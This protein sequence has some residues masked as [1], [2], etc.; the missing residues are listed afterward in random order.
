[1]RG[2]ADGGRAGGRGCRHAHVPTPVSRSIRGRTAAARLVLSSNDRIIAI[3]GVAGAGQSTMLRP[4]AA[5]LKAEGRTLLGLAFQNKMVSD[6]VDAGL[7]AQTIASFLARHQ[8]LLEPGAPQHER[9]VPISRRRSSSSTRVS[10]NAN[11]AQLKLNRLANLLAV[12]RMV[13]M[14]D[15][16]QLGAIDAGKPFEIMQRTGIEMAVMPENLR[17]R[18]E[19][20]K[21]VA[22]A[23]Q[24]GRGGRG[25]RGTRT[26]YD[27][28]TRP[29][30]RCRR[31]AV[32]GARYSKPGSAPASMPPAVRTKGRSIV[33][34]VQEKRLK[35]GEI[36]RAALSLTVLDRVGLASEELRYAHHYQPGA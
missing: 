35:D 36:G 26:P 5:E 33:L 28:R 13:M 1:M 27:D 18:S 25:L 14:G 22:G 4:L 30:G 19:M 34:R 10:M 11:D 17:A 21:A 12:P 3:Q 23:F 9:R 8:H 7:P 15:H 24:A 29:D 6:L 16:R 2:T 32:D 31:R 20:V